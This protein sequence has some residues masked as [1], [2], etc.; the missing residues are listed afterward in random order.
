MIKLRKNIVKIILVL[1]L[2]T[3]VFDEE[4]EGKKC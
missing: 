2:I 4:E 3:L 1:V